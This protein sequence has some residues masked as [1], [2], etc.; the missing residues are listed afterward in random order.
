MEN[1]RRPGQTH[2]KTLLHRNNSFA[3]RAKTENKIIAGLTI[4]VL[5]QYSEKPLAYIYDLAVL[6][7]FQIK[8]L[9]EN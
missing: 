9:G 4:Y 1:N 7:E 5:D 3:A 8:G 2:L 6:P